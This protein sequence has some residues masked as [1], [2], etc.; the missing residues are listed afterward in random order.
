MKHLAFL[1]DCPLPGKTMLFPDYYENLQQEID[2]SYDEV[3]KEELLNVRWESKIANDK[4]LKVFKTK[5]I[6]LL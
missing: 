1:L 4:A 6:K 2:E 3:S 5:D